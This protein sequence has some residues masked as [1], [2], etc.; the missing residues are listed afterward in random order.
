MNSLMAKI[1][2]M[3]GERFDRHPDSGTVMEGFQLPDWSKAAVLCKKMALVR[4]DLKYLAWDIITYSR[5]HSWYLV[6]VNTSGQLMLQVGGLKGIKNEMIK[7]A[8]DLEFLI[9]YEMKM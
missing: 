3:F 8:N 9:P 4:H 1:K 5:K 7:I 2:K 6:E